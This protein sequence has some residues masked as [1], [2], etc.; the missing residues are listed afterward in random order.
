MATMA[1]RA[2]PATTS[3]TTPGLGGAIGTS[4]ELGGVGVLVGVTR[5]TSPSSPSPSRNSHRTTITA[6]GSSTPNML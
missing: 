5:S 1:S 3:G 6:S 2:V 4:I